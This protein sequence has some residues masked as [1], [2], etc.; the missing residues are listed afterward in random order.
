MLVAA[1]IEN[2]L[3]SNSCSNLILREFE[4][5]PS[6]I[7][8]FISAIANKG[9]GYIIIGAKFEEEKLLLSGLSNRFN[10]Q[11]I[12]ESAAKLLSITPKLAYGFL[13]IKGKCLFAIKVYASINDVFIN[14]SKY[15]LEGTEIVKIAE[16]IVLDK[17]KVF[18]VHGHDN[19]AKV[20]T[21]RFVESLGLTAIILHEQASSGSTIIEKIETYSNVG[22][23]IVLYTPCDLGKAKDDENLV[24]R[25]RQNVVFEH[26]YLMGKIGRRNVCALVKKGVEKPNDISGVVYIDMDE[27]GAWK[28]SLIKEMKSSGYDI[29]ANK[30]Y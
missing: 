22:F 21:A 4:L 5:K 27:N 1:E 19:L 6:A 7:A 16:E 15:V 30:M 29:D 24:A 13:E 12:I 9:D 20:E 8:T 10:V 11:N 3:E 17:T 26:G 18:I 14:N 23:G 28:H 2:V 25:A